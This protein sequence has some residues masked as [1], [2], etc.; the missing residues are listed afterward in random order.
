MYIVKIFEKVFSFYVHMVF[1][2][3]SNE[4]T[5]S[6]GKHS[7]KCTKL[8]LYRKEGIITSSCLFVKDLFAQIIQSCIT[9]NRMVIVKRNY[10]RR[11]AVCFYVVFEMRWHMC[12]NN[13]HQLGVHC[14]HRRLYCSTCYCSK[15]SK[16][17]QI[18]GV[19]PYVHRE[20]PWFKLTV[21]Q[22]W[23][24]TIPQTQNRFHMGT[25]TCIS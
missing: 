6:K 5:Y 1:I 2:V 20:G 9:S 24:D 11:H 4:N 3:K 13:P 18:S 8:S 15:V 7:C 21:R 23:S 17:T 12:W 16:H 22:S 19:V 14:V 10:T 25:A